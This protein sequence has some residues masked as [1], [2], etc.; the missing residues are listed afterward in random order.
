MLGGALTPPRCAI[1]QYRGFYAVRFSQIPPRFFVRGF[2]YRLNAA[3][4]RAAFWR[5]LERV[6]RAQ[7]LIK[8]LRREIGPIWPD[9]GFKFLI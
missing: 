3:L 6:V 7:L 9:N 8:E 4:S 5:R 2:S 1:V